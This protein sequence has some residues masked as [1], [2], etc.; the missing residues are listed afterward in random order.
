MAFVFRY[1]LGGSALHPCRSI[2][3][4]SGAASWRHGYSTDEERH[5]DRSADL[6]ALLLKCERPRLSSERHLYGLV[7][8]T[9][10]PRDSR[11]DS[12]SERLSVLNAFRKASLGILFHRLLKVLPRPRVI[13]LSVQS[14]LE[15]RCFLYSVRGVS[16]LNAASR[17]ASSRRLRRRLAR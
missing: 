9:C 16:S 14:I 7:A 12:R 15:Q 6:Q 1:C 13:Y 10:A 2:S 8:L 5:L 17:T 11:S 4:Q 3:R